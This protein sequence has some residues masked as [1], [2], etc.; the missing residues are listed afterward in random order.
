MAVLR[1]VLITANALFFALF[2]YFAATSHPPG[3]PV[4]EYVEGYGPLTCFALNVVY[5]LAHQR[6]GNGRIFRL[7]GLWLDAKEGELRQRADRSKQGK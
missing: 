3:V 4:W 1:V 2:V 5:L 7:F 6:T